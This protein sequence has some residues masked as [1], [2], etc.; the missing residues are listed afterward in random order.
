MLARLR[1]TVDEASEEFVTITDV[2][3][4]FESTP[5]ER[6]RHL[7]D[8]LEDIMRRKQLPLDTKLLDEKE[9]EGCAW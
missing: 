8:C 6:T 9:I 4:E 7:K 2:Y 1:M 3:K 5:K